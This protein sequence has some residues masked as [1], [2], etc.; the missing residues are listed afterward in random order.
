MNWISRHSGPCK[1]TFSL[2]SSMRMAAMG[3]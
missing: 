2:K 1:A 3:D